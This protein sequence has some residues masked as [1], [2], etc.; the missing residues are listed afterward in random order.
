MSATIID[1]K[2]ISKTIVAKRA[3]HVKTL[4]SKPGLAVIL[5]GEDPA[6][7]VYVANKEKAC[8]KIGYYSKKI[9][10]PASVSKSRLLAEIDALNQD[11]SIHGI[12]C[13]F[14]LP[15]SLRSFEAEVINHIHPLKDV[16]G[17][18]PINVGKL[19]TLT[20]APNE[21]DSILL[22]CTPKGIVELIKKTQTDITGKHAVI[23]G[24]SNIVGKPVANLLLA[25]NAT[26]TIT[27]SKTVNLAQITASADIL[28]AAIGK[29]KFVTKAM[30]KPGAIV[31]DVGI[32]RTENGLVGDVDFDAAKEIA[33]FITPVPGGVGPM[34]IAMLMENV[35]TAYTLQNR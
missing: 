5:V 24:R 19:A 32:N 21:N 18:H 6:S 33:S 25:H 34:T 13:Q 31:I 4:Q 1:G 15:E 10:L 3:D 14:P 28:I 30:V 27:H 16:D 35:Y 20:A 12:L 9:V 29:P 8:Q 26:V 22:P 7:Q 2:S 11:D 17:F 23:I